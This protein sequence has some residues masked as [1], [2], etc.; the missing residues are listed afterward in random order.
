MTPVNI[1]GEFGRGECDTRKKD[2]REHFQAHHVSEI[3]SLL[4]NGQSIDRAKELHELS[5]RGTLGGAILTSKKG[6][7]CGSFLATRR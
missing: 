5:E 4:A 3:D 7:R 1:D 2:G 6:A